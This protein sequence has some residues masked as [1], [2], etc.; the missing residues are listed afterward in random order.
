MMESE[1]GSMG[2][3]EISVFQRL[4]F[5]KGTNPPREAF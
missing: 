4:V 5:G 1:F 2:A 3:V